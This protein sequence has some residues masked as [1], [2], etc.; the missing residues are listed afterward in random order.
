MDSSANRTR[1]WALM[2]FGRSYRFHSESEDAAL[3]P[4][5]SARNV[6]PA[7]TSVIG[8]R[9]SDGTDAPRSHLTSVTRR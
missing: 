1:W 8:A 2:T 5:S 3:S 6:L 4:R 7:P 9:T